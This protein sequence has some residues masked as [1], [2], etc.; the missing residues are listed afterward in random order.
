M[1]FRSG[2]E[3]ENAEDCPK[4]RREDKAPRAT[5]KN[6]KKTFCPPIFLFDVNI[7]RLVDQLEAKTPKITFK[8]KNVNKKKSKLYLSDATVHSEMMAL[9]REKNIHSYS[10]TPKELKQSSFILRGLYHDTEVKSA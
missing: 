2:L 10:Y 5:I 3:I 1:L 7:K 9:L 8:I 4:Q 6:A